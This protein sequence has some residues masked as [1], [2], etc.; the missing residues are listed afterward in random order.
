[1]QGI[2]RKKNDRSVGRHGHNTEV[3]VTPKFSEQN[4]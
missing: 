4:S 3:K 1:M 2:S